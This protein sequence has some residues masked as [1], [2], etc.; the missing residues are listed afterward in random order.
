MKHAGPL[1]IEV[2]LRIPSTG[3]MAPGCWQAGFVLVHPAAPERTGSGT[4]PA[5]CWPGTARCGCAG[6]A[7]GPCSPGRAPGGRSRS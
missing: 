2:K 4:G 6:T 1:E 7:G 5:N 3:R